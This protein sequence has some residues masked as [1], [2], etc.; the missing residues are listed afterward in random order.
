LWRALSLT[1]SGS[2]IPA[3]ASERWE[4]LRLPVRVDVDVMQQPVPNEQHHAPNHLAVSVDDLCRFLPN[5]LEDASGVCGRDHRYPLRGIRR[6]RHAQS[7]LLIRFIRDGARLL[8]V[9]DDQLFQ[10]R[11]I[12]LALP[13][14]KERLSHGAPSFFIRDKRPL[15]YFHDDNFDARGRSSLMCP[16]P[17]GVAE[18]LAA[19]RPTRFYRPGSSASGALRDWLGMF[20]DDSD[21][22]VVDWTDVAELV[23]DA[24]RLAAPKYLAAKLEHRGA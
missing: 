17:P 6:C 12:A 13:E 2:P 20:L 15:C 10:L 4:R 24:Y 19:S 8:G 3:N 9:G 5:S 16:A 14:V 22:E 23:G 21:C 18:A 7:H 1:G 11:A